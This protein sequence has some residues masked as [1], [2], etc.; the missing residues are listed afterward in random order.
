MKLNR[1]SAVLQVGLSAAIAAL[2]CG[3]SSTTTAP[4]VPAT[5]A[6]APASASQSP[7]G[8]TGTTRLLSAQ[9][10]GPAPRVG[11]AQLAV[12]DDI[13]AAATNTSDENTPK[14]A[15]RSDGS[16]RGGGFGASK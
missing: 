10:P 9:L 2:A 11:K 1:F 12:G 6:D 4:A 16:R 15:R 5:P 7:A 13:E 8:A 3:C 14:E